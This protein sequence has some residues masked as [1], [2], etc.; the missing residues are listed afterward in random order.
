[1]TADR[2]RKAAIHAH[3]KATGLPY[4]VARR[5]VNDLDAVMQRHPLLN[6]FGIGVFEPFRKTAEQR[7][8]ELDSDRESLLAGVGKVWETVAWLSQNIAPIKTPTVSSYGVKHVMERA[9]GTYVTNGEFIAAALLADYTFT[10]HQH[11]VLFGMSGRD[12]KRVT[13]ASRR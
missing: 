9:T 4:M 10:Y 8:A 11:N 1:M 5:Q 7:R 12:L 6:D 3:Q 13:E 2:R